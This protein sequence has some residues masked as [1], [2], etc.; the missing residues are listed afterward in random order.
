MASKKIGVHGTDAE[1]GRGRDGGSKK[2]LPSITRAQFAEFAKPLLVEISGPNTG[3]A[4]EGKAEYQKRRLVAGVKHFETGSE[5]WY[6]PDKI[7]M[8]IGGTLVKVQ[9]GLTFTI[10]GSKDLPKDD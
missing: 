5:G 7:D 10:V 3:K 6:C 1:T 9:V 8:E 4:E 2:T